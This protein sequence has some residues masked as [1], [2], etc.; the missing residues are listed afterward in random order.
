MEHD[1]EKVSIMYKGFKFF[2]EMMDSSVYLDNV[3][4]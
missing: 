1:D 3:F 2:R 4:L